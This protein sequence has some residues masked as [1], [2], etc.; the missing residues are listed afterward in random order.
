VTA[1]APPAHRKDASLTLLESLIADALDP[2]YL[3]AARRRN[4]GRAPA[5]RARTA[6]LGTVLSI[7]VVS[8]VLTVAVQ[9]VRAAAPS[10][11]AG[12]Q[13]LVDRIGKAGRDVT[14]LERQV[15]TTA[16]TV[17]RLRAQALGGATTVPSG[18]TSELN[19]LA[20]QAGLTALVGPGVSVTV[21]D[22]PNPS[23]GSASDDDLGRVLDVDL[24]DLVNGLWQAGAEAV[25]INGHRITALSAIRGAG[26]AVLVDYRPL[27]RPYVV[28]A[29]GDGSRLARRFRSG[30]AGQDLEDLKSGYGIR[31]DLEVH[32]KVTVPAAT[33]V[34]LRSVRG[35]G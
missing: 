32:S 24:Q 35:A 21:D 4:L 33:A 25:S 6:R 19:A 13:A 30:P 18:T 1:G 28:T 22:A 23:S 10:V 20:L 11:A 3:E 9:Q 29:I 14:S 26:D 12:R 7:V 17:D 2:G 8:V 16:A 5:R 34:I 31:F 15:S 27:A